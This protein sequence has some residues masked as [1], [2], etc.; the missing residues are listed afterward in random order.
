MLAKLDLTRRRRKKIKK[1][2]EK[3][4]FVKSP[5]LKICGALTVTKRAI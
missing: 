4:K 5:T 3:R 2:N 1:G